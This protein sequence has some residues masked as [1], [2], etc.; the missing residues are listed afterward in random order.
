VIDSTKYHDEVHDRFYPG[1]YARAFFHFRYFLQSTLFQEMK[2][3]VI[4]SLTGGRREKQL[5]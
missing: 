2:Q 4:F 3:Q 1:E 5:W